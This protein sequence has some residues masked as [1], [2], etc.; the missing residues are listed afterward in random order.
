MVPEMFIEALPAT[1]PGLIAEL[2]MLM[3]TFVVPFTDPVAVA[4][5]LWT[6]SLSTLT[7]IP[8]KPNDEPRVPLG[9]NSVA[10][11]F[12][13]SVGL[14]SLT[15]KPLDPSV[16]VTVHVI[17][18]ADVAPAGLARAIKATMLNVDATRT[19]RRNIFRLP[20]DFCRQDE[21]MTGVP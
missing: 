19:N 7:V 12:T 11:Q 20:P 10:M 2:A 18:F 13:P 3:D 4:K 21:S 17:V 9:K 8:E 1:F 15:C 5:P 14:M 16:P 6:A